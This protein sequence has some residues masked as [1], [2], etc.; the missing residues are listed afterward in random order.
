MSIER[1]RPT[2]PVA[3]LVV[4]S[5]GLFM[6][7]L[8][9]TIVNIAIP[10]IV[11]GIHAS[12]DQ[13]LWVLNAYSLLY[14]VLLIT[15]GRLG[16]I[17]GPR[18]LFVAGIVVFTL[19]SIA[20]GLAQDPTQL[21]LARAVQGFGAA[22]LAPQGLPILLSLFPPERRATTFAVF[23]IL[24]GVAVVAGPTVGGFIVTH[25][26]WR[27]IFYVNVPLGIATLVA[28][29][30]IVP[31][32]R[33]G[34][35]HRLDVLGVLLATAGLFGVVF[36]LIEGQRYDWGTVRGFV[37][38][39][40]I[41]GAGVALLVIFLVIQARRQD[42]EPL[43]NF[44]IFKDRNFTLMTVVLMA[45]GFAIVGLYLPLTIFYQ[46]VL[47]LSAQDAG[48]TIAVQPLA[49]M[50]VSAFAGGVANRYGGK[51]VLIPGLVLFAAGS[52]YIDWAVHVDASRWSFVPGLI[53]SGIGLGGVWGPVYAIAT[54]DIKP[55]LAGVAS[56]VLNTIQELGAVVASASVG[57]LLQNRL[58]VALHEQAVQRSAALP[59]PF[60]N[61]FVDAFSGAA[62]NGLEIGAGQSGGSLRL[63][64]GV[65]PQVVAQLQQIA[66]D[67][68]VN[69]FVIAMRPTLILP[70]AVVLLAA[71]SCL[72]V[73][74][75][76]MQAGVEP[77]GVEAAEATVAY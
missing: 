41:I 48:L 6:T 70:I 1:A 54:R 23:G 45:M 28:A 47:G 46:S 60:R 20:S 68:F 12:L 58:A 74:N 57:A 67:V 65:P 19:A 62:K 61:S 26:G 39:P 9:L 27:W 55:Q 22:L 64:P 13:V 44:A 77:A 53:L 69:A 56:G 7:L 3:V 37:T 40:E 25:F 24:A 2:N 29:L 11:D 30:L 16:D 34:R 35:K 59:E 14:A 33:P 4:I 49:M 43:L 36:G 76:G 63:P 51:F 72:W 71:I 42:R 31:D 17:F 75:R 52:A 32:L 66:H 5:L 21:I 15:S 18:N 73:R 50:V 10:N 8:D 38:I